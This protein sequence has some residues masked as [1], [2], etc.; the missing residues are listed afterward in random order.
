M[1]NRNYISGL[2]KRLVVNKR[3]Q[4]NTKHS[5]QSII[6]LLEKRS[7]KTARKYQMLL[8]KKTKTPCWII[9]YIALKLLCS[10]EKGINLP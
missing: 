7:P 10:K 8:D 6:D 5:A 2:V 9:R 3:C 4:F 1:L